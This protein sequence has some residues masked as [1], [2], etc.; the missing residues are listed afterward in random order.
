MA[1]A[2]EQKDIA[3]EPEDTGDDARDIAQAMGFS[4]FGAQPRPKAKRRKMGHETVA[5]GSAGDTIPFGK[6]DGGA[7][8]AEAARRG[9]GGRMV[10]VETTST[11]G[12]ER[13]LDDA[14]AGMEDI[15]GA[16]LPSRQQRGGPEARSG[17]RSQSGFENHTWAEWKS[18]VRDEKGDL[19]F[20]DWSFVED[21]WE[22]L[23]VS[24]VGRKM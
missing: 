4:S 17:D 10:A 5:G 15:P 14:E 13:G 8:L 9:N 19:A 21:P 22:G 20:F 7:K 23:R 11:E 1:A 12:G 2:V 3:A 16:S 6:R 18:G 24:D